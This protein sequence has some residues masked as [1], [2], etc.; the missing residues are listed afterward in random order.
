[1]AALRAAGLTF[2]P[3]FFANLVFACSFGTHGPP[4]WPS[5]RT[6]GRSRRRA[7]EYV[8]LITGYECCW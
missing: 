1:V 8:A 2:A 3:I 7:I 4:I 6:C 5:R